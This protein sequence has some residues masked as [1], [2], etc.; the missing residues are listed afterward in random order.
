MNV[1]QIS[2]VY[3]S[4]SIN[5]TLWKRFSIIIYEMIDSLFKLDCQY[6]VELS[7]D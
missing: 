4:K 1:L 6:F 5:T 2:P 3:F 7:I